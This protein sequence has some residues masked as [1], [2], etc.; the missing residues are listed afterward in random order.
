KQDRSG[1]GLI[2]PVALICIDRLDRIVEYRAVPLVLEHGAADQRL[3]REHG[4]DDCLRRF[5]RFPLAFGHVDPDAVESRVCNGAA[6]TVRLYAARWRIERYGPVGPVECLDR[7]ESFAREDRRKICVGL[8]PDIAFHADPFTLATRA[9]H[10][11]LA[12]TTA[13]LADLA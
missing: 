4:V 10:E 7:Q 12:V 8:G 11:H 5:E 6:L 1:V 2:D 9:Q 3:V 13:S